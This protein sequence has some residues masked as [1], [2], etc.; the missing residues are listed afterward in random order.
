LLN[1]IRT[2]DAGL[3]EPDAMEAER[4]LGAKGGDVRNRLGVDVGAD[5]AT[6]RAAL[7]EALARWQRRAEAPLAS[8]QAVEAAR[9][10]VRT[11]EALVASL[12]S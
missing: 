12:R 7:N 5:D 2:G 8:A 1:A 10:V 6:V 9:V 11:C 3:R 4:L